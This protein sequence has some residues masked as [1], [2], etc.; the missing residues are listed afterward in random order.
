MQAY[1]KVTARVVCPKSIAVG[2]LIKSKEPTTN[3][4]I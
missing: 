4:M 1:E 2:F 3:S